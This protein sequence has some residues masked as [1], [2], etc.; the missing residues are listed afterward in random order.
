M[1]NILVLHFLLLSA[2]S[3]VKNIQ[4]SVLLHYDSS[5]T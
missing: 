3:Y 2:E 4:I 1:Q 5:S